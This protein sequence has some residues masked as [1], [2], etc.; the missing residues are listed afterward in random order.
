MYRVVF[1]LFQLKVDETTFASETMDRKGLYGDIKEELPLGIPDTLG[2]S[3]H[4]AF[5]VDNEHTG[6]VVTRSLHTG[7]LIYVMND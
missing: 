3:A 5:F 6:N 1:D 7:V 2:K 4:T